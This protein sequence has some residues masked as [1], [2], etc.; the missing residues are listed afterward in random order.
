MEWGAANGS[1]SAL[2]GYTLQYCEPGV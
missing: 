1:G 2:V